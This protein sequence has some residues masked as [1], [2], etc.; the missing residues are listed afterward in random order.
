M[1]LGEVE[2]GNFVSMPGVMK[3]HLEELYAQIRAAEWVYVP[4]PALNHTPLSSVPPKFAD[5][6]RQRIAEDPH[7]DTVDSVIRFSSELVQKLVEDHGVLRQSEELQRVAQE[8]VELNDLWRAKIALVVGSLD[9]LEGAA[10]PATPALTRDMTDEIGGLSESKTLLLADLRD[11]RASL[12]EY[13][14]EEDWV[15]TDNQ[16]PIPLTREQYDLVDESI[17]M[18]SGIAGRPNWSQQA[19]FQIRGVMAVLVEL[20]PLIDPVSKPLARAWNAVLEGLIQAVKSLMVGR[21]APE[22]PEPETK[23]AD[24]ASQKSGRTSGH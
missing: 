3:R 10:T 8:V 20:K 2:S 4:R 5:I 12:A 14:P 7:P 19:I 16:K 17:A 9:G 23:S 15:S 13:K 6:Y 21:E 18:A 22:A 24:T 11:L 1:K